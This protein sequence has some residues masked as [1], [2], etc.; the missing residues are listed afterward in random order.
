MVIMEKS[1]ENKYKD[2][3]RKKNTIWVPEKQFYD[4]RTCS[5][6]ATFGGHYKKTDR[7]DE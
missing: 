2:Y 6:G 1:K 3:L 5:S 7:G 4:K